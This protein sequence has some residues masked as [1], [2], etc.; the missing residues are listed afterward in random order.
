MPR[1]WGTSQRG[2]GSSF[3]DTA[4]AGACSPAADRL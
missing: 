3:D 1:T 4:Q 2:W